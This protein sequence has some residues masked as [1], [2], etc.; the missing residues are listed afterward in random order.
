[1]GYISPISF[2]H[3]SQYQ[4]RMSQPKKVI[5]SRIDSVKKISKY[6]ASYRS[7]TDKKHEY[8]EKTQ[9]TK[10]NIPYQSSSGQFIDKRV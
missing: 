5:V 4:E 7:F 1:M 9:Q 2:S 3:Y 6:E 8:M 10:A